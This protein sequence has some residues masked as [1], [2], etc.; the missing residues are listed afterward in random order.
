VY[1]PSATKIVS[2][3]DAFPI[4]PLIVAHG[5]PGLRQSLESS[6]VVETY[7]GPAARAWPGDCMASNPMATIITMNNEYN[8]L[9][10]M[11]CSS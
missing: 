7:H 5:E 2:P 10:N 6:P 3:A 8:F 9:C 4:A 1:V 11:A